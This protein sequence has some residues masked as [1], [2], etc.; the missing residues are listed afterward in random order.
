M[1][2]SSARNQSLRLTAML[3]GVAMLSACGLGS[4]EGEG[5]EGNEGNGGPTQTNITID[6][7]NYPST[8]DPGLQY[9]GATYPVYRNIYD[10]LLRRDSDTLEPVPWIAE[11]W[12][13]ESPTTWR[14]T[15]RDDVTFSD[16]SPLTAK[17]AAFSLNR[18]LDK[19][20]NSP[21]FANFS[22][23]ATATADSDTELVIETEDPS[24]TLLTYL[25]TLS[26]VSEEY[27][28]EVGN[29]GLNEKPMGSGAYV[30]ES[31][32]SGSEVKLKRNADYWGEA[33]EIEEAVFRAV[34]N[35][36][37][38]VAD[39][40]S[41]QADLVMNLAADQ[42]AELEGQDGMQVLAVPTERV[43]YL[44]LNTLADTP[45]KDLRVRQAI[46]AAINYDSLIE[47]L[48]GGFADPVGA[49]LTPLSF[50]YP[51]DAA[52]YEYDPE[53]ARELLAEAGVTNPVLEFPASPAYDP[54]LL[55]AIQSDLQAVGFTVN[56]TN[57]DHATFLQ[58]VQDPSHNWGSIRFGRWSCSC[59][60]ADGV[61]YPLFRTGTVW[62]SYSNPEFDA[63]VDRGRTTTEE[64]ERLEAYDSA[65][66]MLNEDLPGIGLFQEYAIYGA[67][68]G[69][70][71]QPD[72]VE[73]VYLDQMSFE[74]S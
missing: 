2:S 9:D 8:L 16:G 22:A 65:F 43:D 72:A 21:Q 18:I 59:L 25:T 66:A 51:D 7:P 12:E 56:I 14:F 52:N 69:L 40:R 74:G 55:Q 3:A 50:G 41:G 70:Q 71:W 49:V 39:L 17:D 58:K 36:S 28:D 61:I 67:T 47:N 10:Q 42:A 73:S 37:T 30:L 24:A 57:T 33:P 11:S 48:G 54:Q 29:D 46:A 19:A 5:T 64:A 20:L 26:I 1:A 53:R 4:P 31:L 27:V 38:R 34:P 60:D 13:Q 35:V 23:V 63:A 68:A 45:T 15:L 6:L 44:A 62:S 32:R